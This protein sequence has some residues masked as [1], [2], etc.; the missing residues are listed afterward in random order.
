MSRFRCV[1]IETVI[2]DRLRK[3]RVD[4]GGNP[5]RRQIAD[6]I[7]YPCRHCLREANPGQEVLLASYHLPRP[8]GLYWSASPIFLHGAAC[9]RYELVDE[10]PEIVRNRLVSVRAYGADDMV[11]YDLGDVANGAEVDGLLQR[12]LDDART[13][14]VN[15]HTARPGCLLCTIERC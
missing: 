2:V 1:P 11:I 9:H 14:Y 10:V 4:D 8:R 13:A 12:C 7:G 6:H 15:V 3:S 5:V